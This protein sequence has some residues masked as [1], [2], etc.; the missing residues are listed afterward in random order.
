[1]FDY[2][3]Y[4]AW[5]LMVYTII[6]GE[7]WQDW[8]MMKECAK[9]GYDKDPFLIMSTKPLEGQLLQD[10]GLLPREMRDYKVLFD[11]EL[12]GGW[13]NHMNKVRRAQETLQRFWMALAGGAAL[14]APMILMVLHKDLVTTLVTVSVSVFIFAVLI[15]PLSS[16]EPFNIVGATAA[17]AAVLVV[18]V[19]A[20]S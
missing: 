13:R 8:E 5:L 9:Q 12:P 19:G 10:A 15:A 16:Q 2:I 18:F 20:S 7:A 3:I 17:Y 1:M 14:V 11:P 6:L 4:Y